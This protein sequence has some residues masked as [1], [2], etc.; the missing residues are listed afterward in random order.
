MAYLANPQKEK[1]I[2][3]RIELTSAVLTSRVMATISKKKKKERKENNITFFF[4]LEDLPSQKN[5]A[6]KLTAL[7]LH[8]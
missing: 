8:Y 4:S 3:S 1:K 6:R 7:G 5:V 2:Y